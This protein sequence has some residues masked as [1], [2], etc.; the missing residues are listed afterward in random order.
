MV[1][2]RGCRVSAADTLSTEPPHRVHTVST[3]TAQSPPICTH[4]VDAVLSGPRL[5]CRP[6]RPTPLYDQ[7]R[8]ERINADV[9]PSD[10][11][12]HQLEDRG[13][14]RVADG[15][16]GSVTGCTRP[17]R[18]AA[19]RANADV[20]PCDDEPQQRSHP[21]KHHLPDGEPDLVAAFTRR[22]P[23]RLIGS[24]AGRGSQRPSRRVGRGES[25]AL[26]S[27]PVRG[28]TPTRADD[29]RALTHGAQTAPSLS[30]S[31]T[32]HQDRQ[33]SA[34]PR[35]CEAFPS[36]RDVLAERRRP[37]SGRSRA[38]RRRAGVRTGEH[39]QE[40]FPLPARAAR[41]ACSGEQPWARKYLFGSALTPARRLAARERPDLGRRRSAGRHGG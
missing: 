24:R 30:S 20:A 18:T 5:R 23:P 21:A 28:S 2:S 25:P 9:P 37:R 14:H 22:R 40:V 41:S 8:G 7:L 10:A 36:L 1:T 6:V 3:A 31:A 15:D 12:P 16:L 26:P 35:A 39:C 17:P 33:E 13:K 32:L 34:K 27:A 29:L 19:D 38:A 11:Q 4:D